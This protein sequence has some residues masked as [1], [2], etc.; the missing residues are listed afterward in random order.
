M[1]AGGWVVGRVVRGVLEGLSGERLVS[2][3]VVGSAARGFERGDVDVV[4]VLEGEPGWDVVEAVWRSVAASCGWCRV[5]VSTSTYT[6][7]VKGWGVAYVMVYGEEGFARA[8]P[9]LRRTWALHGSTMAGASLLEAF[10][11]PRVGR[12]EALKAPYGVE[13]CISAL[14]RGYL[15]TPAIYDGVGAPARRVEVLR[16]RVESKVSSYCVRWS[17]YN[18]LSALGAEAD[19]Y[20]YAS[21]ASTASRVLGVRVPP[22]QPEASADALA[23]LEEI[24][25]VLEG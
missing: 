15:E 25:S 2:L 10:G 21:L 24:R 5:Y 14:R 23:V 12:A 19:P 16:G 9:L 3:S 4:A 6:P 1:A 11:A 20:D 22:E 8:S 13:W 18:A 17:L 7:C